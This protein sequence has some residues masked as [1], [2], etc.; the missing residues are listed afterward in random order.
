MKIFVL[1]DSLMRIKWFKKEY[2]G[3][4]IN[5]FTQVKEAIRFLK[6]ETPDILYL[7]HD[8]DGKVFV[9]SSEENTGY[10][11]AKFIA[12]SGKK[13][14]KIV[15]HSMNPFG[16]KNMYH[17]LKNSARALYKIPFPFLIVK[18]INEEDESYLLQFKDYELNE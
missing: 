13:Y 11:L 14:D 2:E 1:E 10:Q 18:K 12:E 4:E 7:D 6:K 16:A 5:I 3:S 15:I 17:T 8:L 9:D